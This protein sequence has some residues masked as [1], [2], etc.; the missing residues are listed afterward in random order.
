MKQICSPTRFRRKAPEGKVPAL[1]RLTIDYHTEDY[2]ALIHV[3]DQWR[4]LQIIVEPVINKITVTSLAV[5]FCGLLCAK[6]ASY[7]G[8]PVTVQCA[9]V[10]LANHD[11]SFSPSLRQYPDRQS[12]STLPENQIARMWC[13]RSEAHESGES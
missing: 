8:W 2:P 12:Q 7:S 3:P 10:L 13:Q 11:A 6:Y 5:G 9:E 1:N 4:V